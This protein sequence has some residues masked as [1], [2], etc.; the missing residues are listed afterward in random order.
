M[1]SVQYGLLNV[2]PSDTNVLIEKNVTGKKA[3]V[4]L[5][6]I[7]RETFDKLKEQMLQILVV[8]K[9]YRE[10]NFSAKKLAELLGTN[11]R[12]VSI[13]LSVRYHA[14]YSQF[15]NKLRIEE[16]MAILADPRYVSLRIEE[17]SD[18][19]GFSNRQSFYRAFCQYTGET[20]RQY[21]EKYKCDIATE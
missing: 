9:K 2:K 21:Q 6:K 7:S 11:T 20:P 14:N 18:M 17:I 10:R 15:V 3:P 8:G 12:Y 16:A 5:S 19:V 4:Y 13:V 1:P